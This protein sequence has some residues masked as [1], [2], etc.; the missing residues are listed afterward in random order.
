MTYLGVKL[1]CNGKNIA[2]DGSEAK[3]RSYTN[4]LRWVVS[5]NPAK[6]YK[7]FNNYIAGYLKYQHL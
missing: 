3:L 4:N 5:K 7:L 2:A 1:R 6:G